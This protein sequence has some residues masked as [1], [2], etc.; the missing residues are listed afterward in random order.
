MWISAVAAFAFAAAVLALLSCL[1]DKMLTPVKYGDNTKISLNLELK[2]AEPEL[3][4]TLKSLV[5]LSDSGTLT[6][7]V[8]IILSETDSHTRHIAESYALR[9]KNITICDCGDNTW[10]NSWN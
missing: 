10:K 1:K 5:W 4:Q 3:E 2:G 8:R 6:A 7:P 9:Y